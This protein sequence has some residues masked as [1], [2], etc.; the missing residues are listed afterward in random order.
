MSFGVEPADLR[1]F[2]TTLQQ[3]YSDADAAKAYVHAHGSFSFHETGIIGVLSGA[4]SEWVGK[5]DEM[6]NHLQAL[7]D[8]SSRALNEIATQYE[9]SD[10][11]SAARVDATY[12]VALR[13]S[14]NRD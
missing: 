4:H 10:E 7:T 8:S 14:V 2:A 13:P 12:P 3:A 6:L 5:L 1:V 9:A 11:D